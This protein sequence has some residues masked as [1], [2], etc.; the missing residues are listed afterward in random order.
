MSKNL[1]VVGDSAFAQIA[2]EY[3]DAESDYRV[4]GF[5]VEQAYL[6]QDSL[7]D[8]PVVAF[9]T[10]ESSFSPA[11]HHVF[12]AITY[13]QLNRLR[14][15]LVNAAQGRGYPLASFISPHAF[16]WRNVRP[17]EHCFVFE[18]NVVQ[19]FVTIGRNVILWS[20]NHIGHHSHIGENCFV[21]S[22]VTLSGFCEVG[23]NSFIGVNS[24]IANN[25]KIGRDNW[26]GPGLT[27]TR[28]TEA[29][30]LFGPVSAQPSKVPATRYFKIKE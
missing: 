30:S 19:P 10:L 28:D 4:V 22:H 2:R 1:V 16:V 9:E 8:L 12:V 27:I 3:F 17:G 20:G 13:T 29:D 21:S 11:N 25:V 26:I 24:C 15:R 6:K 7:D 18:N 23:P 5:S 14:T